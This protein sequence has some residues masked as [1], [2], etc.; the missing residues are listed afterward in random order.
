MTDIVVEVVYALPDEQYVLTL[1][2]ETGTTI[3]QAMEKVAAD[4]LFARFPLDQ[5]TTGIWGEVKPRD[6]VLATGDRLELYRPL[7]VDPRQ[8]R[9]VRATRS[10]PRAR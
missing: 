9:Q 7:T 4:P 6:H 5:L 10:A 1:A 8:A 3:A 2:L